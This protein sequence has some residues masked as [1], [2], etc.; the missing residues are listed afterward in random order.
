MDSRIIASE[1]DARTQA[2][3]YERDFHAWAF[4]QAAKVRAGEPLDVENVAEELESLGKSQ[5][6]QLVNRLAILITHR[7]KWEFQPS[8]RSNSC[9]GTMREQQK[10]IRRL[11]DKNP[12]LQP[13]VAESI[14]DAHD[15]AV[16]MASQETGIVEQEFPEKCPYSIEE[17]MAEVQE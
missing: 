10:R 2:D 8:Q 5:R 3:L 13:L 1:E 14:Q 11:L 9:R 17:L 7:L 15:F 4:E 16:T 6:Q 12:S